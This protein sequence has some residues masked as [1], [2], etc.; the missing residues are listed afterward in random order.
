[1]CV[2]QFHMTL[3]ALNTQL[4]PTNIRLVV[5]RSWSRSW[6][7]VIAPRKRQPCMRISFI[8]CFKEFDLF[9]FKCKAWSPSTTRLPLCFGSR[10]WAYLC[11]NRY[12]QVLQAARWYTH[13]N[14]RS[15][16]TCQSQENPP[17]CLP[18]FN[19][20]TR[21]LSVY[22]VSLTHPHYLQWTGG[23]VHGP[24]DK[25]V[26]CMFSVPF[27]NV[28]GYLVNRSCRRHL[29]T[30]I[31]SLIHNHVVLLI[32]CC[33]IKN[34]HHA[35][36]SKRQ[37]WMGKQWR[38]GSG[39]NFWPCLWGWV[40]IAHLRWVSVQHLPHRPPHLPSHL[41]HPLHPLRPHHPHPQHHM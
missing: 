11:L 22:T 14:T 9:L 7:R 6:T 31:M 18:S 16:D 2:T 10:V 20:Y 3:V 23:D 39:V 19:F 24:K 25:V 5:A 8:I 1:M 4:W 27:V 30:E 33:A 26:D 17:H 32:C 12:S 38:C 40:Q 13:T 37:T 41:L 21:L 35:Q 36:E 29:A 34:T 15:S 28:D